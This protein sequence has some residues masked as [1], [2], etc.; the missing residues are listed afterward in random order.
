MSWIYNIIGIVF[1]GIIYEI[2]LPV[3]KINKF[4]KC[5]FSVFV[6]NSVMMPIL[7]T[8]NLKF[9]ES[10]FEIISSEIDNEFINKL[11]E[12]KNA[13][14]EKLIEAGIENEG[15]LNVNVEIL[16]NFNNNVYKIDQII[17]N[18]TNCVLSGD[19]KN[20]NKYEVITKQVKK[21]VGISEEKIVFY[22]WFS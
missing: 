11:N 16:N 21:Y 14:Y 1:I 20:I 17:I 13:T 8:I 19:V 3:G 9:N 5:V 22:E 7:S 18:L 15:I 12:S 4:M 10:S 2:V 6:L